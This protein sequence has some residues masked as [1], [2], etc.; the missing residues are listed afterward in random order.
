MKI[1]II[2]IG[3]VGGALAIALAKNGYEIENLVARKKENAEKIAEFI[4]SNILT[5]NE[6]NQIS[7]DIIFIT[8]QD[9]EIENVAKSLAANM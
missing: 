7:S 6:F 5:E 8:T 9:F 2:G 1:S 4:K 3:R